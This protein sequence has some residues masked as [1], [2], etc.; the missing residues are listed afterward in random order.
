MTRSH[1]TLRLPASLLAA[2]LATLTGACGKVNSETTDAPM[3]PDDAPTDADIDAPPIDS[4]PPP[5]GGL[6]S[7]MAPAESCAQLHLARMP[8]GLYWLRSPAAADP[9]FQ[10]FCEQ[11]L[12]GGG[13]VMLYNSVRTNGRTTAFWQFK[14]VDRLKQL[15]SPAADQNYYN[16]SLYLI[17]KDY[18]DVITDLQG[19]TVVAAVM[20]ATGFNAATMQFTAPT[21]VV[22]NTSIFQSQFAGGWSAQDYDG[23]AA[24]TRSCSTLYSNVAQHYSNCWAYNLGSDADDPPLDGGVG[25]HA[26]TNVLTPLNLAVQP[27][28]GVYSQV[29]RIA[30]YTRW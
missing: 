14:Y 23:D 6:G 1:N 5:D 26:N 8:S 20:S 2:T 16:G 11:A 13:W 25:P 10:A 4:P 27:N 28:G 19:K 3:T 22:G 21:L 17:G 18:M 30:R 7:E 24:P 9:P 29:R 12:N 15:G